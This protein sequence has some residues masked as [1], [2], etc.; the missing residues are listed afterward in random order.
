M[1]E[2]VKQLLLDKFASYYDPRLRAIEERMQTEQEVAD[3]L[4][5]GTIAR[6]LSDEM[7]EDLRNP[8][9]EILGIDLSEYATTREEVVPPEITRFEKPS[10]I[11][12]I[13]S[14]FLKF[15]RR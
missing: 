2:K 11:S 4:G 1:N 15:F 9:A 8:Q 13:V 10:F 6:S 5:N 14:R 3:M 12:N 7:V